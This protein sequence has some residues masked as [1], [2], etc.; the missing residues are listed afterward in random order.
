LKKK[1]NKTENLLV[2]LCKND[3]WLNYH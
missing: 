2:Y 3:M 1:K